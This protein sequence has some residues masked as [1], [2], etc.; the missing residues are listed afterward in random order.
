METMK[1][2]PRLRIKRDSQWNEWLVVWYDFDSDKG[3]I[4]NED[5]TYHTDDKE[6]ALG[7]L[8]C[9]QKEIDREWEDENG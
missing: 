8:D 3:W 7:T 1:L 6:D 2:K 5:K 4:R 9:I